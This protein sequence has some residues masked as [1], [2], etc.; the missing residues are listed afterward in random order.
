MYTLTG[1]VLGRSV[2]DDAIAIC[3]PLD[4]LV[5]TTIDDKRSR[6]EGTGPLKR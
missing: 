5:L 6:V 2:D 4:C 3:G 1:N